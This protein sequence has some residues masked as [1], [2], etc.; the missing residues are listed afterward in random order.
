MRWTN[1]WPADTLGFHVWCTYR[2]WWPPQCEE[3]QRGESIET[4]PWGEIELEAWKVHDLDAWE[5][6]VQITMSLVGISYNEDICA[7]TQKEWERWRDLTPL[8]LWCLPWPH[9]TG[10]ITYQTR[11]TDSTR[12]AAYKSQTGQT[13][14]ILKCDSD[15][16]ACKNLRRPYSPIKE[17][18][19][20]GRSR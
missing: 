11:H 7:R 14:T 1:P 2:R 10:N 4:R 6:P 19:Y 15:S 20:L 12:H 9:L 17:E 5:G 3:R 18:T 8:G 13:V 16:R